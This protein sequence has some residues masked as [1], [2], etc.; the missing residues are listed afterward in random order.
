[1]KNSATMKEKVIAKGSM[2]GLIRSD[3]CN[4]ALLLP[5]K[6]CGVDAKSGSGRFVRRASRR[7]I[8]GGQRLGL[9][10]NTGCDILGQCR[11]SG[12]RVLGIGGISTGC[13]VEGRI[14]VPRRKLLRMGWIFCAGRATVQHSGG[15]T[16]PG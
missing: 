1:M 13:T 14:Q 12:F 10:R 11:Q 9:V 15:V 7:M 2:V 4:N 3:T 8:R 5:K 6:Y 16:N